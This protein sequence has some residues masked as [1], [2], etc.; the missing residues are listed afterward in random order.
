MR[1]REIVVCCTTSLVQLPR[2]IV[3]D[4]T[5]ECKLEGMESEEAQGETTE[6]K[7]GLSSETVVMLATNTTPHYPRRRTCNLMHIE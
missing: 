2:K 5:V 1:L 4:S 3:P 6:N 7:D